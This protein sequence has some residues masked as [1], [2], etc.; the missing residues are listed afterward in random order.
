MLI[1]HGNKT[2]N[3]E[4][5]TKHSEYFSVLQSSNF[6]ENLNGVLDLTHRG[7]VMKYVL[8]M[9]IGE[10]Y[11]FKLSSEIL[12][13]MK[14]ILDEL[15]VSEKKLWLFDEDNIW[16]IISSAREKEREIIILKNAQEKEGEIC[17]TCCRINKWL[18][19]NK[20]LEWDEIRNYCD[21]DYVRDFFG[22]RISQRVFLE[23]YYSNNENCKHGSYNW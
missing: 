9:L 1:K 11:V 6:S 21:C 7:E 8:D 10:D 18:R 12:T 16:N 19:P 14:P 2:Y 13:K 22:N 4:I 3:I 15:L 20:D 23:N 17:K 5:L